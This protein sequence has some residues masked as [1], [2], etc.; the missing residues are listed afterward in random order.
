MSKDVQRFEIDGNL[1]C[2]LE[3][4]VELVMSRGAKLIIE[5]YDMQGEEVKTSIKIT[6]S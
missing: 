5:I 6:V 1:R 4:L 3:T 2:V